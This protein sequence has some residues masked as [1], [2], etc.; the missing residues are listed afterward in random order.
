MEMHMRRGVTDQLSDVICLEILPDI[1]LCLHSVYRR[2]LSY[3]PV[4]VDV[5]A[6]AERKPKPVAG[7][8]L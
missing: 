8:P 2:P 4:G 1:A 3:L 7:R 5:F 6:L